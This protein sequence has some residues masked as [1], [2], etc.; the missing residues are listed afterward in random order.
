MTNYHKF[1]ETLI[2]PILVG[3]LILLS[4]CD[5]S[6]Q[7][8]FLEL[9]SDHEV[10]LLKESLGGLGIPFEINGNRFTYSA[11]HIDE[12]RSTLYIVQS[13]LYEESLYG[14]KN[15]ETMAKRAIAILDKEGIEAY[16]YRDQFH[17]DSNKWNISVDRKYASN[18]NSAITQAYEEQFNIQPQVKR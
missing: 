8:R 13:G 1:V 9:R 6:D 7:R 10:K 2:F 15:S 14:N 5:N 17:Q 4:S 18:L 3:L 12:V 11:K 16:L